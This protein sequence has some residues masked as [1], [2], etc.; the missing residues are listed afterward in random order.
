MAE[1]VVIR[2]GDIDRMEAFER[3]SARVPVFKLDRPLDEIS[4]PDALFHRI[5][6]TIHHIEMPDGKSIEVWGFDAT[7][8]HD[9]HNP[10]TTIRTFPS[11]LIRLTEGDLFHCISEHHPDE[12]DDEDGQ[13]P[14]PHQEGHT[15][16]WHGIEP[17]TANDGVGKH[18]FGV[19]DPAGHGLHERYTYQWRASEAGTYFYHCHRNTVLHVEN[20]MY[21]GLII[22]PRSPSG[23]DLTA[24]YPDGGPGYVRRRDDVV[25]YDVERFWVADEFDSRWHTLHEDAGLGGLPFDQQDPGLNIFEPDYFLISGVPA[26]WTETDERIVARLRVGETLLLRILSAGYFIHT[27]TLDIDAEVIAM[28]GRALGRSKGPMPYSQ[29]FVLPAGE[30]FELTGARRWDLLIR[31]TKA[32]TYPVIVQM[33]NMN[34]YKPAVAGECYTFIHVED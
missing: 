31:P 8:P 1:P 11:K 16:H 29:P 2:R 32:G 22:D 15:I 17:T 3:F 27:W 12:D 7:D 18:S 13:G 5:N 24:P 19:R 26:P 33:R 25:R 9:P 21:G 30:S 28:D 14:T 34:V 20:G 4:P 23:S 10:D 6:H